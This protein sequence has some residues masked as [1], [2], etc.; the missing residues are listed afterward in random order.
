MSST[1]SRARAPRWLQTVHRMERAV[2]GPLECV[3][4]SDAYFDLVADATRARAL[5]GRTLEGLSRRW[6]HLF[7]LPAGS[8][9]RRLRE[10]QARMERRL[11]V[12]TRELEER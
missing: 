2:G 5:A 12:L 10:Q 3:L 8:D 6:L 11:A 9:I 1:P 7:N 4:H